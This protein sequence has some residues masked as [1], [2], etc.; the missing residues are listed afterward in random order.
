M[1]GITRLS[2]KSAILTVHLAQIPPHSEGNIEQLLDK[3]NI[4]VNEKS[5]RLKIGA[6]RDG[7]KGKET[8]LGWDYNSHIVC[9]CII[10]RRSEI[11]LPN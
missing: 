11:S 10:M 9:M 2:H 3:L 5:C 7:V 8:R 6:Y 1:S 4:Q